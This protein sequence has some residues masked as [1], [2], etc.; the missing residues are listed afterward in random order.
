MD[1]IHLIAF[2]VKTNLYLLMVNAQLPHRVHFLINSM[3]IL[4]QTHVK[5]VIYHVMDVLGY[6]LIVL[7]VLL[8]IIV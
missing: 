5:L 1:Q 6:Q 8:V 3:I 7:S 2:L 4:I